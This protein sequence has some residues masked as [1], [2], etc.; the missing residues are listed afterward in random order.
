MSCFI[1][2][3]LLLTSSSDIVPYKDSKP[4]TPEDFSREPLNKQRL[5][6]PVSM[7]VQ[8]TT[9]QFEDGNWSSKEYE[10]KYPVMEIDAKTLNFREHGVQ[11]LEMNEDMKQSVYAASHVS[12]VP[13][14]SAV[15]SMSELKE[16]ASTDVGKIFTPFL[17]DWFHE[18]VYPQYPK[19]KVLDLGSNDS[20]VRVIDR[21]GQTGLTAFPQNNFHVDFDNLRQSEKAGVDPFCHHKEVFNIWFPTKETPLETDILG[22]L[23][24][25]LQNKTATMSNL[26][27]LADLHVVYIP[28]M[29]FGDVLIFKSLGPNAPFHGNVPILGDEP[30]QHVRRSMDLR[31]CIGY[32]NWLENKQA[33]MPY[34]KRMGNE[35]NKYHDKYSFS[36]LKI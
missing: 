17:E 12:R 36:R 18:N 35:Q 8:I 4:V 27:T 14:K 7:K 22:F 2:L 11:L 15:N 32:K 6:K 33:K 28:K 23:Y 5:E 30:Y 24:D 16:K 13:H 19:M 1:I 31:G 3:C 21:N 26:D 20:G 9:K 34:I 25:P 29:K 10:K